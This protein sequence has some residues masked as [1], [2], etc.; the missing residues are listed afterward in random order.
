VLVLEVGDC[1]LRHH[2]GVI[3][4][5]HDVGVLAQAGIVHVDFA[6]EDRLADFQG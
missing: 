4:D 3:L 5:L 6:A 1:P 2:G